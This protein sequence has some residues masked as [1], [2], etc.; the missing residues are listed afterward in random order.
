MESRLT[1]WQGWKFWATENND[2][3]KSQ[4]PKTS[5]YKQ[6]GTT[7]GYHQA[8]VSKQQQKCLFPLEHCEQRPTKLDNSEEQ[9]HLS[10]ISWRGLHLRD[11]GGVWTITSGHWNSGNWF[12]GVMSWCSSRFGFYDAQ[13]IN[14]AFYSEH[15]KSDKF[16]SEALISGGGSSMCRKCT[17]WDTWLYFPSEGSHTQDFYALKKSIDPGW[18]WTHEPRIQRTVW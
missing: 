6:Q 10:Y 2:Q 8:G 9:Q 1:L 11:S 16:C 14:I 5:N 3:Q 13:V 12:Y 7:D 4:N 17:T 18:V 15:E